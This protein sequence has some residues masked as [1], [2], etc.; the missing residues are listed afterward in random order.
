MW[1]IEVRE[2]SG[3][4][5]ALGESVHKNILDL[6]FKAV[7]DVKVIQVYMLEGSAGE[8]DMQTI[9]AQLLADCVTQEFSC[10]QGPAPH[11]DHS[12]SGRHIVEIAYHPGVMD[13]VEESTLK[14]IRDLGIME[15]TAVR[16]ARQYHIYGRISDDDIQVIVDKALANKLIQHVVAEDSG[17]TMSQ[18]HAPDTRVEVVSVDLLQADDARLLKV[19]EKGQLFLNLD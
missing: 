13:P 2:K 6:G 16:T 10:A 17:E 1:R 18:A 5:D 4:F 12:D 11:Y 9:G 19:S 15:V 7:T 14:G 8:S 3:V